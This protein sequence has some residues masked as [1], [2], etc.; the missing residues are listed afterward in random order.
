MGRART[1]LNVALLALV[2]LLAALAYF[3]PGAGPETPERPALTERRPAGVDRLR[4]EPRQ[5]PAAV[6]QRDGERWRLREPRAMPAE[7]DAVRRA[8]GL[9]EAES[10]AE[11]QRGDQGLA[12]YGLAEPD[13]VLEMGG[14]RF[15]IG[16][17]HPMKGQRY[18]LV[19]DT[20]HLVEAR[21]VR[22]ARGL[23]AAEPEGAEEAPVVQIH[24]EGREEPLRFRVLE[25]GE[26]PRLYRPALGLVYRLGA[27]G[28]EALVEPAS[29]PSARAKG[30]A[31]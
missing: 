10:R 1:W 26:Q 30:G 21:R 29:G 6:L 4:V 3:R 13:A 23:E 7:A 5:G 18:V 14:H 24:L 28:L 22:R 2:V 16:G 9:L 27:G 12:P 20:L 31:S 19:D 15:V 11:V 8:L 25:G 17:R